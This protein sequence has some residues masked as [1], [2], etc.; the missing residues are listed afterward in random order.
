MTA[1]PFISNMRKQLTAAAKRLDELE[2]QA[3][4][5]EAKK[6]AL[7]GLP[8]EDASLIGSPTST[9]T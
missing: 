5:L 4:E 2:A 9:S 8:M 7:E 1:N 3:K 6:K